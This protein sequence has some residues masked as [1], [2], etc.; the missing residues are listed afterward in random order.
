MVIFCSYTLRNA[1]YRLCFE[2]NLD[3]HDDHMEKIKLDSHDNLVKRSTE[4]SCS[5]HTEEEPPSLNMNVQG[6]GEL[7]PEVLEYI[8]DLS[9]RLVSA[10]QVFFLSVSFCFTANFFSK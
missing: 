6:L 2:R 5:G 1:E 9:D 10:R 3:I 4:S 8:C 7:S